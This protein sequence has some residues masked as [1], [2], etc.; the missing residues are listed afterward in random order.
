LSASIR[1]FIAFDIDN[2]SMV[3]RLA[4]IQAT[5]LNT[6]AN[7]KAV[8]PS[9]IHVTMRFLG[10]ISP[11]MVGLIYEELKQVTFSAFE[12][13]LKGVGAFPTL[14]YPRVVWAGIRGGVDEL[15]SIFT[16]LEQRLTRLGFKP[17]TRGFSPHLTLARVRTGRHKHELVTRLRDLT[18]YEFGTM[19]VEVLRLKRS[20]LTP[21][22]AIY[23]TLRE[24]HGAKNTETPFGDSS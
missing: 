17:E 24:V 22:G 19:T 20:V 11:S 21:K 18:E 1:S 14:R 10:N 4:G 6:G 5:L 8:N 2:P 9:N 7:L 16:Q 3:R 12:I 15:T 13:E 23:T